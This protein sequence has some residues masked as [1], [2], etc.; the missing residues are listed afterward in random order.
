MIVQLQE[1]ILTLTY[2][3]TV[4]GSHSTWWEPMQ[5]DKQRKSKLH[6]EKHWTWAQ[7]HHFK[8]SIQKATV[9][10]QTNAITGATETIIPHKTGKDKSTRYNN[11]HNGQNKAV[12]LESRQHRRWEKQT[13]HSF[14]W[15]ANSYSD[16]NDTQTGSDAEY[17][18]SGNSVSDTVIVTGLSPSR[19]SVMEAKPK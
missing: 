17:D 18:T 9:Y 16:D 12:T 4:C 5:A 7:T 3:P 8:H 10:K 19:T 14:S 6:R 2:T 1:G 13:E 11:R 15:R